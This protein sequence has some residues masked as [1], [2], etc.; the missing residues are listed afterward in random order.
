[1]VSEL[2]MVGY[3]FVD[4]LLYSSVLFGTVLLHHT[5]AALV[6]VNQVKENKASKSS[7]LS[8]F[9]DFVH[10]KVIVKSKTHK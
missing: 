3:I 2:A 10:I 6:P 7:L 5:L 8:R 4:V 9:D 1:M